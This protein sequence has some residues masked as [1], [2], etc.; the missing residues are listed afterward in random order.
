VL[1]DY[2]VLRQIT[3]A[4]AKGGVH[5]FAPS[6]ATR[7]RRNV[8]ADTP[9]PEYIAHAKNP[10]AGAIAYYYLPS[11]PAHPVTLEVLDASGAVIRHLSS[12]APAPVPEA[13]HPPE[14]SFWLAAPYAIPA[15]AGLNR[16]VWDLRYDAPPSFTHSFEI[17]AN[18]GETP[19]SPEGPLVLP[20]TYT[21]R[22]TVDGKSYTQPITVRNDPRE[23]T[24]VAALAA[25]QALMMKLDAGINAA[26]TD[27]DAAIALR[28]A[29]QKAAGANAAGDVS[30]AAAAL[31]A[32]LDTLAG[33]PNARGFRGRGAAPRAPSFVQVSEQLVRELE[34]Q[35]VGDVAPTE[36]VLA[37]AHAACEQLSKA[38]SELRT[39]ASQ[40]LPAYNATLTK[41]G[42]HAVAAPTLPATAPGC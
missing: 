4:I 5:L 42:L 16:A 22:L 29:V 11:K 32:R 23:T 41:H 17:N 34:A 19:A 27:H 33:N 36:G 35:D 30:T 9:I 6:E 40:E 15:D 39:I 26:L 38:E 37:S 20:G 24:P 21:L 2:A 14:P 28:D 1:D 7:V 18:P 10:P 12:V 8:G 3:P 13:S 25:Q 31:V